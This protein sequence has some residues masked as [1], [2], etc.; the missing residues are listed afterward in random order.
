MASYQED[1]QPASSS[2]VPDDPEGFWLAKLAPELLHLVALSGWLLFEDVTALSKTSRTLK[3]IFV[4]DDYARDIHY[5]L[6]GAEGSVWDRRWRSARYAVRRR[7]FAYIPSYAKENLSEFLSADKQKELE[8]SIWSVV[9]DSVA[10]NRAVRE[11]VLE[12]EDE[13]R[14]WE[15][16]LLAALSLPRASG[17]DEPLSYAHMYDNEY[18]IDDVHDE[19]N[20]EDSTYLIHIAAETG[21][22]RVVDWLLERCDLL[23]VENSRSMTPLTAACAAGKVGMAR[24]LVERGARNWADA[25]LVAAASR[26]HVDVARMLLDSKPLDVNPNAEDLNGISALCCA[27]RFRRVDSEG[28]ELL[29]WNGYSMR[30]D[31]VK[32]LVKRGAD[33]NKLSMDPF[34]VEKSPL[35]WACQNGHLEIVKVLMD[36]GAGAEVGKNEEEGVWVNG[37]MAAAWGGH[38]HVVRLLLNMGVGANVVGEGEDGDMYGDTVM[39]KALC[40]ATRSECDR[41]RAA[42]V[43]LLAGAGADVNKAGDDRKTPL[44]RACES[45]SK[46]TVRVL[47]EL[48]ADVGIVDGNG[49]SALDAV[50]RNVHSYGRDIGDGI[51]GMLKEWEEK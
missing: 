38:E 17:W 28:E 40:L 50:A 13:L 25:G 44:I 23:E 45:G 18:E 16:L 15:S 32:E 36:A 30:V 20:S 14:G 1:D 6:L 39:D 4:D 2:S 5:A 21:S 7:W 10:M 26:G 8:E 42:V 48:G 9:V 47:L 11:T 31:L 22:E 24:K 27:I 19:H 49:Q 41:T 43:C 35:E 29:D 33:V 34:D 46:D 3:N 51:I 12:D 37:L